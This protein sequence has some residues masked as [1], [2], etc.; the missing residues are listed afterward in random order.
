MAGQPIR[1]IGPKLRLKQYAHVATSSGNSTAVR[2]KV[3]VDLVLAHWPKNLVFEYQDTVLA[4]LPTLPDLA[5]TTETSVYSVR[6]SLNLAV[7]IGM[8]G[9]VGVMKV[10][11]ESI[12][13]FPK[14]LSENKKSV[15][16]YTDTICLFFA[17]KSR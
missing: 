1:L 9:M 6:H 10:K 11:G 5:P 16:F 3:V 7:G 12:Y 4:Q 8:N 2:K 14:S 15:C 13:I 17:L